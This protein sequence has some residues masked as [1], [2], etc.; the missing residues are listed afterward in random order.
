M[1]NFRHYAA[2]SALGGGAGEFYSTVP[3]MN[4][5]KKV[6]AGAL[7]ALLVLMGYSPKAILAR[8]TMQDAAA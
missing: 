6:L 5:V 7:L 2:T 4:K 3:N 8:R 1:S